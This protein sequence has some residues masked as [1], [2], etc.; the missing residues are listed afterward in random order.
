MSMQRGMRFFPEAD[1]AVD[2][3]NWIEPKHSS[4]LLQRLPQTSVELIL[5]F[6][7][8][9]LLVSGRTNL[10]R[11]SGSCPGRDCTMESPLRRLFIE[12]P[13]TSWI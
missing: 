10:G 4:S 1:E 12:L 6:D 7:G 2:V 13:A 9:V 3:E 11:G 5:G 8:A